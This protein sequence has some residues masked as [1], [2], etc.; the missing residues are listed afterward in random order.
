MKIKSNGIVDFIFNED[1]HLTRRNLLVFYEKESAINL[2]F[3]KNTSTDGPLVQQII[4][5]PI[6][7]VVVAPSVNFFQTKLLIQCFLLKIH[8]HI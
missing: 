1:F 4:E 2:C 5:N 3:N 7:T 6:E 8:L